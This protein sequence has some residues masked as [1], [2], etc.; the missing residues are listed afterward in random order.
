MRRDKYGLFFSDISIEDVP[1]DNT[2]LEDFDEIENT[3]GQRMLYR[4]RDKV[5]KFITNNQNQFISKEQMLS[6][7]HKL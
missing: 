5:F 3:S 7:W 6:P 4:K 1:F 2:Q